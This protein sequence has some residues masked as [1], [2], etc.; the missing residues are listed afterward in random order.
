MRDFLL[1][2]R[3]VAW[4]WLDLQMIPE[5]FENLATL[6]AIWPA[7]VAR[8]EGVEA[9]I[10]DPPDP[11]AP[12]FTAHLT[13]K[14]LADLRRRRRRLEGRGRLAFH[15]GAGL[16]PL[17]LA[18]VEAIHRMRQ[19]TLRQAG[20][21]R[22]SAFEDPARRGALLAW[23]ERT[24][25]EGSARHAWLELD[26]R[27][28]AFSLGALRG[29]TYFRVMMGFDPAFGA[30][31]PSKLLAIEALERAPGWGARRIHFLWGMNRFKADF[32][33]RFHGYQFRRYVHP[34]WI[35]RA[36]TRWDGWARRLTGRGG[37]EESCG[38]GDET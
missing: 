2:Q 32:A 7:A 35:A 22:E 8:A 13:P 17:V 24:A 10:I 34:R 18:Q 37:G 28:I 1:R 25:R 29:G 27:V 33:N 11:A 9:A 12:D 26:G 16:P 5:H 21:E 14:L 19:G 36:R 3:E 23:L 15:E 6:D 4:D 31:A 38:E 20:R 30:D